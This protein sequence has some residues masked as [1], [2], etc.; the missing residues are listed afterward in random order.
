MRVSVGAKS[1]VGR[2][3]EGNEDSYLVDDPLF[4]VADGM[5][6]H[7]AGDVASSTA[8]EVIAS[9]A[10]SADGDNPDSLAL[11]L[12]DANAAIYEKAKADAGLRGMGTTCT[13][14]MIQDSRGHVAHV[15]DSRACQR[16]T[17]A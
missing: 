9:S 17:G 15:G 13:L 7:L 3:R 8:V 16:K 2:V 5:G 14:L 6:G 1:D 10:K 4:A 11:L 12:R